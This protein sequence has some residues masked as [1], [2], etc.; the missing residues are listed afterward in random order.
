MRQRQVGGF[1]VLGAVGVAAALGW[2]RC[3]LAALY[4][5]PCPGCGMTRAMVLLV[6]GHVAASLR[7]NALALP[8]AL[9]SAGLVVA[10]FGERPAGTADGARSGSRFR[11]A[12]AAMTVAYGAAVVLWALR[13][14]GMFGG[15]VPV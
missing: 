10:A 9:A 1:A 12:I 4:H 8:V 11:A 7:M 6:T 2:I 15:P 13:W 5:I 3:P 14:L